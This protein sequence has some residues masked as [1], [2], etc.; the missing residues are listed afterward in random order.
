M[1]SISQTKKIIVNVFPGGFNWPIF[2]GLSKGFFTDRGI[3]V[4]IQNT[5]GSVH[6]MTD[7]IE[8]KC[9]IVMTGFDNIVA[10]SEGHGERPLGLQPDLFA[11]LGSDNSFLS[12]VAAKDI[13]SI[14]DLEKQT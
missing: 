4:E 2:V 1:T 5:S 6:Q 10:Y 12:L 14:R 9:D 7:F 13:A 8:E 11:F 3:E